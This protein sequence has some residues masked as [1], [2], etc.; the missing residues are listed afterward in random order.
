MITLHAYRT[1]DM[2]LGDAM[3]ALPGQELQGYCITPASFRFA[4]AS[5]GV[6]DTD[7]P[8]PQDQIYEARFFNPTLELRWLRDPGGNGAGT[9]VWLSEAHLNLPGWE[10]SELPDLT[11]LPNQTRLL[12]GSL[13]QPA[14][15]RPGWCNMHAPRHGQVAV[16][17][18]QGLSGDRIGWQVREYLG[19]APGSAGEDGNHMVVEERIIAIAAVRQDGKGE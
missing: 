13:A 8:C 11:A 12:T 15:K 17:C 5:A 10:H 19:P 6:I 16:P 7:A 3:G 4:R 14:S 18:D 9:A 2:G 1:E